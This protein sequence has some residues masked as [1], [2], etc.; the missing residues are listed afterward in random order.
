MDEDI[1]QP[2]AEWIKGIDQLVEL[3][4]QVSDLPVSEPQVEG[5]F[6]AHKLSY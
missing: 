5:V 4:C 1:N 6:D 2:E 3:K